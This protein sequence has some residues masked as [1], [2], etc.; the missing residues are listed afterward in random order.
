MQGRRCSYGR[1]SG[2]GQTDKKLLSASRMASMP[3]SEKFLKKMIVLY[4]S[5]SVTSLFRI[6]FSPALVLK[7]N[8]L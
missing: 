6:T 1:T 8:G 7:S 5:V 4:L 3:S 2:K